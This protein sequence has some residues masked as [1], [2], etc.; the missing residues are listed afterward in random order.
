MK[1]KRS[2]IIEKK[3]IGRRERLRERNEIWEWWRDMQERKMKGKRGNICIWKQRHW[4]AR[5]MNGKRG[6]I[7]EKKER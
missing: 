6:K 3:E 5:N 2:N 7:Y 1:G 4:E